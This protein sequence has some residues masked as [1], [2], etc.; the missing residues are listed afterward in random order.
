MHRPFFTAFASSTITPL[1]DVRSFASHTSCVGT[2]VDN[3]EPVILS[4]SLQFIRIAHS[5]KKR[6]KKM[7]YMSMARWIFSLFLTAF[8]LVHALRV[9]PNSP[10]TS[11]CTT[12][13]VSQSDPKFFDD[14]WK[15]IVCSDD[16]FDSKPEGK[17]LKSCFTCLQNSNYTHGS[18]NDQDWFLCKSSW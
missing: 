12:S 4:R 18:E 8:S 3:P 17:Q 7:A 15:D 13:D 10:C 6:K 11:A 1:N 5:W 14:Q 9:S 2:F 16:D